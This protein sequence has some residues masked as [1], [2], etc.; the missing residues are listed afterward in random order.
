MHFEAVAAQQRRQVALRLELLEPE[1]GERELAVD[2]LLRDLLHV[3]DRGDDLGFQTRE[4]GGY[5]RGGL[6][7][8][9][10]SHDKRRKEHTVA[11]GLTSISRI[12]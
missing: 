7:I 3:V 8:R 5:L 11:H 12:G 10:A 9:C 4:Y 1:L 6:R 2:D